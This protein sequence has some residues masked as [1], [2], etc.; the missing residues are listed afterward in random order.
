MM[1]T[2]VGEGLKLAGKALKVAADAATE[3]ATET[4]ALTGMGECALTAPE[5]ITTTALTGVGEIT[6]Q[7]PAVPRMCGSSLRAQFLH[8]T[9]TT[10]A[11]GDIL[12]A[13]DDLEMAEGADEV[14]ALPEEQME[15][16]MLD[17]PPPVG[18]LLRGSFGPGGLCSSPSRLRAAGL[19]KIREADV[20]LDCE[21]AELAQARKI[22]NGR[23]LFRA[24]DVVEGQLESVQRAQGR[25]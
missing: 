23:K 19:E 5:A 13:I 10:F 9:G 25:G 17:K 16:L 20:I 21:V 3:A 2:L 4:V 15:R 14:A 11:L 24:L 7:A 12:E 18:K 8:N 1:L 6:A 22:Q